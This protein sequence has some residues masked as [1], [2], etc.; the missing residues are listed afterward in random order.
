VFLIKLLQKEDPVFVILKIQMGKV[1]TFKR[2]LKF[3]KKRTLIVQEV[4]VQA[5]LIKYSYQI[6]QLS[7]VIPAKNK[8]LFY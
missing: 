5:K 6:G 2:N 3:I 1:E 4:N 7:F 8:E